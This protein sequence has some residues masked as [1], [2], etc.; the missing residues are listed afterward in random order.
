[1]PQ[2]GLFLTGHK[3]QRK[4]SLRDTRW[5]LLARLGWEV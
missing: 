1:M 3:E 2:N 5:K 4:H